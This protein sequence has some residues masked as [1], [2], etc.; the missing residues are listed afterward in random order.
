VREGESRVDE[1]EAVPICGLAS[2][3]HRA[4]A[5]VLK[6]ALDLVFCLV[7]FVL[8][9]IP[10]LIIIAL[11]LATSRG[12]ILFTQDRVGRDGRRFTLLKFRTMIDG[13]HR[14]VRADESL[15][16]AYL[17]NDFKL[18]ADDPRITPL[19]R[20]LRKTSLD[21]LPQVVNVFW[22]DMSVVGIRPLLPEELASRPEQDQE[23]YRSLR[24]GLTGL[25]QV[26]GRSSI[27][28]DDRVALDRRYVEQWSIVNDLK[29]V[30][31]TPLAVLRVRRAH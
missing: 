18:P 23:L 25:W 30:V 10:A 26:E 15:R 28:Q 19:G 9:T 14:E 24:P 6:R 12:P 13:T 20:I 5:L 17:Q 16:A 7:A 27:V 1:T 31:R 3:D 22:G 29:I 4:P 11:V 2:P 21:E 8:L